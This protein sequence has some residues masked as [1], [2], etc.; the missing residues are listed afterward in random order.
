MEYRWDYLKQDRLEIAFILTPL[1]LVLLVVTCASLLSNGFNVARPKKFTPEI[2]KKLLGAI[3]SGNFRITACQIAGISQKTLCEWLKNPDEKYQ[4]FKEELVKAEA[5]VESECV[6]IILDA[7]K[8]DPKWTSWYLERK[9]PDR[10]NTGIYRWE[11]QLMQKQLKEMKQVINEL[12]K[13]KETNSSNEEG[14]SGDE[15]ESNDNPEDS[16]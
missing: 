7:G 4:K 16:N 13:I 9:F 15:V 10:W 5:C 14:S 1:H 12:N 3:K 6:R 2:I 11:L 8:T